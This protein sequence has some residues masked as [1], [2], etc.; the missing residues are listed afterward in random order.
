MAGHTKEL[1]QIVGESAG[2]QFFLDSCA[3]SRQRPRSRP[4]G[5]LR[6]CVARRTALRATDEG[7]RE[8]KAVRVF[9]VGPRA[10]LAGDGALIMAAAC[11]VLAPLATLVQSAFVPLMAIGLLAPLLVWRLHARRVDGPATTGALLGYA[12]GIGFA[13]VL[14]LV[15]GG[16]AR[17][18]TALGL[19][20][21]DNG[22]GVGG[23]VL[24]GMVVAAFLILA[25]WLDIDALR[26][27]FSKPR[28]QVW[29]DVARLVATAAGVAYF[30]GV[31]LW[32]AASPGFDYI[33]AALSVGGCGAVG[34]AVVT[35]ADVMVR[36]RGQ[37]AGD[38]R[39]LSG[40]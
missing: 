9:R 40:V 7:A 31:F 13:L 11:A 34:A 28:E 16:I 30:V 1:E 37:Q 19:P 24:A 22:S 38:G 12:A 32:A 3:L 23:P 18:L 21:G 6:V 29:L 25:V 2:L 39:L 27:L 35:V 4:A 20:T 5:I 14:L 26:D 17:A 10:G 36:R 8:M 33:A 15:I